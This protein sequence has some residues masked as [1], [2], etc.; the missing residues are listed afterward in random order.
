MTTF[1]GGESLA[2]NPDW[3]FPANRQPVENQPRAIE[4]WPARLSENDLAANRHADFERLWAEHEA[5]DING[6]LINLGLPTLE[7]ARQRDQVILD[8]G[9]QAIAGLV[10]YPHTSEAS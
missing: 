10:E 9:T 6:T 1:V 4:G 5:R 7:E 3:A 8:S 2:S